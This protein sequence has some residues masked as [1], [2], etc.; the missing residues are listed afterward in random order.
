MEIKF[1]DIVKWRRPMNVAE[2]KDVMIVEDVLNEHLIAVKHIGG[3]R[4]T[5]SNER[6]DAVKVV[7]HCT[8]TEPIADILNKYNN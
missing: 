5:S 6:T 7:G 3:K 1:G 2:E 4:V 8:P